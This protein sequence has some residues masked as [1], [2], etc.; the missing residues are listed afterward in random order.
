MKTWWQSV[1]MVAGLILL[2]QAG[3]KKKVPA[4]L[5]VLTTTAISEVGQ[6]TAKSGGTITGDGDAEIITRGVCWSMTTNPVVSGY[7]TTDGQGSGMFVSTITGLSP[8]TT[9][10]VRA[11]AINS[12]GTSYGN[13]IR[14]NTLANPVLPAVRTN[15]VTNITATSAK[16]GGEVAS[17]GGAAVTS[18]G[19]C[20]STGQKPTILDHKTTDGAGTGTFI[21]SITGLNS[22]MPYYARAYATNSAG[23]AYGDTVSF[24]RVLPDTIE[25]TVLTPPIVVV[26]VLYMNPPTLQYDC[27][28]P[29]PM[30]SSSVVSIDV[31]KDGLNDFSISTSQWYEFH[32][33]SMP[34]NNFQYQSDIRSVH[35]DNAVAVITLTT[36]CAQTFNQGEAIS[37]SLLYSAMAET[38]RAYWMAMPCN[39]DKQQGDIYYGF[40]IKKGDGYVYGWLLM[41]YDWSGH[42]MTIREFAIN[43]TV[44]NKI[45][46]GQK[47]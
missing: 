15:Q 14:F 26:S 47:E 1:L 2:L 5:P 10:F 32:S 30:D 35:S 11:Y 37:G 39:L 43:R 13:E 28:Q 27:Y 38:V 20:W 44:N 31:D 36:R 41:N 22:N 25:F 45:L 8:D 42:K 29:V 34:C 9:W 24:R 19:I 21:S 23:T 12:A 6:T 46:A 17:D 16:C 3:C 33:A 4:T 7:H 40:R 18:R